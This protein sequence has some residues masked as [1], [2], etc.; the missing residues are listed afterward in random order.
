MNKDNVAVGKPRIAGSIYKAALGTALPTDAKTKLDAGFKEL[1]YA[2]EDG[3]TNANSRT[4]SDVKAW[5]G[6]VVASPMT[7]HKD[8]LKLKLIE[9]LNVEA[10]KAAF[11]EENVSGTLEAGITVKSNSQELAPA[12]WVVDMI[13]GDCLHRHVIPNGQITEIGEIT[14][15]DDTPVGYDITIT[16]YPDAKGNTHYEYTVKGTETT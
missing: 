13:L 14:Y 15:K 12:E 16:A 7:E 4:T 9:A 10:L 3:L 5:G 6:S 1:G 8:T 11:G 2:S